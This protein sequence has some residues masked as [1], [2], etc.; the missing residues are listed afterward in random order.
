[1]TLALNFIGIVT[2]D[3]SAS[4]AFYRALGLDIPE[5]LDAEPHIEVT[6]PGG[7]TLAWDPLATIHSFNPDFVLPSGPGRIGFACEADSPAAVDAAYAEVTGRFPG[8]AATAPWD[9][10]WGQRYA[11]V[12]DP[13][14]NA[15]DLYAPLPG[16]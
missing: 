10:P 9:A 5:G 13:D 6:L 7:I 3:L 16:A 8:A 14:G 11:T 15:V 4:L 12:H 2:S 1:M